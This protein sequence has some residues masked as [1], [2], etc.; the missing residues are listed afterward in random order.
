MHRA[1]CSVALLLTLCAPVAAAQHLPETFRS[2]RSTVATERLGARQLLCEPTCREQ[3]QSDALPPS[4][5]V[6]GQ[7]RP[8]GAVVGGLLGGVVGGFAGAAI[9]AAGCQSSGYLDFSCLGRG[10]M[11]FLVGEI[12]GVATGAH[13]GNGRR[14]NWARDLAASLVLAVGGLGVA[15]I[16]GSPGPFLLAAAI[17]VGG[18][19][20]V[21][22]R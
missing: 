9:G 14:G 10:A 15:S 7:N 20:A 16:D 5:G 13:L 21:E 3:P 12:I 2:I 19:V 4:D 8:V 11:G 1:A 22:L 18:T 17:Q 6:A